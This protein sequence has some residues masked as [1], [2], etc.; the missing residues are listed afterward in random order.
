MSTPAAYDEIAEWYDRQVRLGRLLHDLALPTL[1]EF[2]GDAL[3]QRICDLA[4]G[5]G[6]VARRLAELGAEVTGVDL[7]SK[8]LDIARLEEES[9][10]LGITY[11]QGDAQR[12]DG[13]QDDAFDAVICN[14]ALMDIPDLAATTRS[15]VRILRPGGRF[16]FSVTHP[17][18]DTALGRMAIARADDGAIRSETRTYFVE[19]PWRG[20][21]PDGVRGRVDTYHRTVSTYTNT[22]V[23]SGLTLERMAEPRPTGDLAERRPDL[24][25][26]PGVLVVRC[27]KP[28]SPR[29]HRK[30]GRTQ[31][32][33]KVRA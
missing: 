27:T 3:G 28:Y 30:L 11:L 26:V 21:N 24:L 5:Q 13:L 6:V 1:L 33:P 9:E 12:L 22:L 2:L 29:P 15:V 20:D 4:C 14:M 8:L 25:R 18:L 31:P 23:E 16:T 17:I 7:S 19:G 10:P 32:K